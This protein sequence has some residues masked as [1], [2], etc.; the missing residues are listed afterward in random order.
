MTDT[1]MV[2]RYILPVYVYTQL[3]L[4][5]D[6][7]LHH[8]E[9]DCQQVHIYERRME[10]PPTLTKNDVPT[11]LCQNGWRTDHWTYASVWFGYD[12]PQLLT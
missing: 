1:E 12:S 7:E 5:E 3:A 6:A 11:H 4:C 9:Q 8:T 2:Q 10:T